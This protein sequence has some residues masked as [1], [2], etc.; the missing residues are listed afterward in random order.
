M[1]RKEEAPMQPLYCRRQLSDTPGHFL[2]IIT[3]GGAQPGMGAG[4]C[5]QLH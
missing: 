5:A 2:S 1:L 3:P 4:S